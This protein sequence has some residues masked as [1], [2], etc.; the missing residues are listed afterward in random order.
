MC[1][2][3]TIEKHCLTLPNDV[4]TVDR[5]ASFVEEVA[6]SHGVDLSV[7]LSLNL[8]LEEAVVNIMNYAY[9]KGS[10][11]KI[12]ITA[13]YSDGT[14]IFTLSDAGTPFDPTKASNPDTLLPA[15]ERPIGG[16]G[17]HLVRQIMDEVS[18]EYRDNH[19]ILTLKKKIK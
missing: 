15:E 16:L 9:P 6:G 10:F 4:E 17:I 2:M 8:A 14:L 19:N 11:G 1:P 5:L 18:Y 13:S 3:N 7:T 12:D